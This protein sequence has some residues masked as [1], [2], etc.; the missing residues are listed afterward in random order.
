MSEVFF[1]QYFF[2]CGR[3]S[4][5]QENLI[6]LQLQ[7]TEIE[8]FYVAW[9]CMKMFSL[10]KELLN[11]FFRQIYHKHCKR[12]ILT[13]HARV[14]WALFPSSLPTVRWCSNL[15]KIRRNFS[16]KTTELLSRFMLFSHALY[17]RVWKESSSYSKARLPF[18]IHTFRCRKK[19]LSEK[20]KDFSQFRMIAA[21]GCTLYAH[22]NFSQTV[23]LEKEAF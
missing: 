23:V 10:M 14:C 5:C 16:H 2:L 20:G 15:C 17:S 18:F 22:I 1:M 7:P 9:F 3:I 6:W 21:S 8:Q 11:Y 4:N 19:N 12:V 13:A